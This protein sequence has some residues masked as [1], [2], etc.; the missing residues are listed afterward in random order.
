MT[1]RE[2]ISRLPAGLMLAR[3]AWSQKSM[4]DF[5]KRMETA[6][7]AIAAQRSFGFHLLRDIVDRKPG[8]NVFISPVSVF[9]ALQMA[10]NGAA[11]RK[12]LLRQPLLVSQFSHLRADNVSQQF[13]F[14]RHAPEME[15]DNRIAGGPDCSN[16]GAVLPC[17]DEGKTGP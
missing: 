6:K 16:F 13:L 17:M 8:Q 10:E 4:T 12:K 9:L 7:I 14:S 3:S 5:E 2:C 15:L 11:G 1:R